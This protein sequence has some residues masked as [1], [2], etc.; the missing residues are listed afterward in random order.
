MNMSTYRDARQARKL[1]RSVVSVRP[2]VSTLSFEPPYLRPWLFAYWVIS[3]DRRGLKVKVKD[4][5]TCYMTIHCG[6]LEYWM[7]A[8]VVVFHCDVNSC[9]ST[10]RIGREF[11]THHHHF[12]LPSS[13]DWPYKWCTL[14][15]ELQRRNVEFRYWKCA[16]LDSVFAPCLR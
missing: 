12:V 9:Y 13:R 8:V 3:T 16:Y 2:C 7:T 1:M 6:V 4:H 14:S 5:K 11:R 10:A 15:C